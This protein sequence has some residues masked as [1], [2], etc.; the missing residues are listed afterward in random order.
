MAYVDLNPIR[1]NMAKTPEAPAHTSIKKRI[2]ALQNKHSQ[3][4][5]LMS[6]VGNPR[7]DMPKGIA[8]H[9]KDYCELL[10][11]TGRCIRE[12][13][14]GYIDS[15]HSPILER[16]GLAADQWLTLTTEFEKQFCYAAG[17]ELMMQAFKTHT[18]HNDFE[19]WARQE[20][21]SSGLNLPYPLFTPVSDD[22]HLVMSAHSKKHPPHQT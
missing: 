5:T 20:L 19:G 4:S 7:Q 8:Y 3:P 14:T 18:N 6:F 16:L 21:Y 17:A 9:I 1:A 22:A 2:Q 15:S 13:K 11:T 12:D 10:A